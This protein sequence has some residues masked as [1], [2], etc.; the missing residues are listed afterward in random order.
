MSSQTKMFSLLL[1]AVL[2]TSC[3]AKPTLM[4]YSYSTAVGGGGGSAFSITGQ[5]RITSIRLWEAANAYIT[6]IQVRFDYIWTASVGQ[7]VGE[8]HQLDLFDDEAIIQISGKYHSNYIYQLIFVTSRGRSLIVGQPTQHSFNFY[9]THPDAELR[10]LSGRHNSA[11]IT[12]LGAHWGAVNMS[13]N[14]TSS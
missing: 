11:G 3:L 9:P 14:S 12:T 4:Y 10:M 1:F 13:N 5:G 6:G 2:C 7:K 8:P